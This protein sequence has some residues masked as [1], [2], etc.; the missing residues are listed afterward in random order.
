MIEHG[1]TINLGLGRKP[2][3]MERR[4]FWRTDGRIYPGWASDVAAL[5]IILSIPGHGM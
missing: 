4:S 3:S 2:E 1:P 5:R